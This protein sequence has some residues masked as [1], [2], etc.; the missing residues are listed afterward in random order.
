MLGRVGSFRE[1]VAGVALL[2]I[3]RLA[4]SSV[5]PATG[6]RPDM[7]N[8]VSAFLLNDPLAIARSA[9]DHLL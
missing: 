9:V 4:T 3:G 1:R 8:T 7:N 5:D 2:G 6:L